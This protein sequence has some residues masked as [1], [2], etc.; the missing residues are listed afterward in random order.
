MKMKIAR[1][2]SNKQR[3]T[4]VQNQKINAKKQ[5]GKSNLKFSWL[6]K[7]KPA[8]SSVELYWQDKAILS[9][10]YCST[11]GIPSGT[12]YNQWKSKCAIRI[13]YALLNL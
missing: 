7:E 2:T 8:I 5:Y 11:F 9:K 3:F 12:N 1:E 10:I 4:R 13:P 6:C